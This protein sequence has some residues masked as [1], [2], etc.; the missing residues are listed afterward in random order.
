MLGG[1]ECDCDGNCASR[2]KPDPQID[3]LAQQQHTTPVS[4]EPGDRERLN[5]IAASF[6]YKAAANP[7]QYA[8]EADEKNAAFLRDL[9]SRL[10][11]Q[12]GGGE[13]GLSEDDKLAVQEET[14]PNG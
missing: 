7:S 8:R 13:F 10:S 14:E 2:A 3:A 9:A 1:S 12:D 4:G 6:D 11:V 5:R